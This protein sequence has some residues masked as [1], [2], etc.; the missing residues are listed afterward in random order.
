VEVDSRGGC[1]EKWGGM[2]LGDQLPM[3]MYGNFE[4]FPGFRRALCGLIIYNEP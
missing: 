2:N 3:Q 4:G 1:R